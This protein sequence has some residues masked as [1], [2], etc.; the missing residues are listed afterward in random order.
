MESLQNVWLQPITGKI[1]ILLKGIIKNLL[2]LQNSNSVGKWLRAFNSAHDNSFLKMS[3]AKI[4]RMIE[5]IR[6]EI[7][8]KAAAA[9][10]PRL[11]S[12]I[13]HETY[14]ENNN[15]F[16]QAQLLIQPIPAVYSSPM[17]TFLLRNSSPSP[18]FQTVRTFKTKR[19]QVP[20]ESWWDSRIKSYAGNEDAAEKN[21][22]KSDTKYT[23]GTIGTSKQASSEKD[24]DM[25]K[26]LKE[27]GLT[28]D[29]QDKVPYGFQFF[30]ILP[31]FCFSASS[32]F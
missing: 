8:S 19:S 29:V 4:R 16:K 3:N 13:S 23:L 24:A 7:L 27:S 31:F 25:E 14:F 12:A 18:Y 9:S 22:T 21:N 10:F 20:L 30:K 6:E 15:G 11:E 5:K 32:C 17:H 28:Q 1:K 26:L 2:I